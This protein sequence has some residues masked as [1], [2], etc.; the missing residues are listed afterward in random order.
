MIYLVASDRKPT[1]LGRGGIDGEGT[2]APPIAARRLGGCSHTCPRFPHLQGVT[3]CPWG[4]SMASQAWV[5]RSNCGY[6]V[7]FCDWLCGGWETGGGAG[8]PRGL[9][10]SREAVLESTGI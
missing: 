2:G 7:G 10:R 1:R 6:G 8:Q 9:G 5:R 4:P 3:G